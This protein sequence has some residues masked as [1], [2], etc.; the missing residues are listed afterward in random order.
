MKT[1]K[2]LS[3]ALVLAGAMVSN[4]VVAE[5]RGFGDFTTPV[6]AEP[7][8]P[9][10]EPVVP[11]AE[12]VVLEVKPTLWN[13]TKG[14]ASTAWGKTS[15]YAVW[16][17]N[18]LV[19]GAKAGY[20]NAKVGTLSAVTWAKT[21]PAKSAGIAAAVA[22]AA[23]GAYKLYDYLTTPAQVREVNKAKAKISILRNEKDKS[24]KRI[25]SEV[26][27]GPKADFE[28]VENEFVAICKSFKAQLQ[29]EA[30]DVQL[31]S[32]Q[33]LGLME[34]LYKVHATY[35]G[36]LQSGQTEYAEYVK[37]IATVTN[38]VRA[39]ANELNQNFDS[40]VITS[41]VKAKAIKMLDQYIPQD[42]ALKGRR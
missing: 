19:S 15:E 29:E 13:K 37:N 35:F 1:F 17:K 5:W 38:N 18:G 34:N 21:N 12:P 25:V 4:Q 42:E 36:K 22:V 39:L 32:A 2:S 31:L 33:L 10:A 3:L 28:K 24:V 41:S 16:A 27:K 20:S 14:M 11:V 23:Y 40:K 6:K 9:V 8:V 30:Y 7:V 26:V